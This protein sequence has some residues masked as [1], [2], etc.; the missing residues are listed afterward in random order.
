MPAAAA[1]A[2]RCRRVPPPP[3]LSGQAPR[4][5]LLLQVAKYAALMRRAGSNEAPT[6]ASGRTHIQR[7]KGGTAARLNDKI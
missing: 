4:T 5:A 6:A 3:L 2:R 1:M 7:G